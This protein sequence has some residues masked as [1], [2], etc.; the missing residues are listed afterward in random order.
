MMRIVLL[1]RMR[2]A[3]TAGS[4]VYPWDDVAAFCLE[5]AIT[6]TDSNS[7]CADYPPELR[8]PLVPWVSF[9]RANNGRRRDA[10]G[11]SDKS[12]HFVRQKRATHFRAAP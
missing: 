2:Q 6:K 10:L 11:F 1:A 12:D 8:S 5:A 7:P 9:D 3:P 4:A